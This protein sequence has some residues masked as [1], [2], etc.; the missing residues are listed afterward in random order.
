MLPDRLVGTLFLCLLRD[1]GLL[2]K[3]HVVTTWMQPRFVVRNE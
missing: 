2:R 3:P 1:A